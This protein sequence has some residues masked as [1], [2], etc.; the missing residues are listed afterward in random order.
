MAS[1]KVQ[2]YTNFPY[3][4]SSHTH[5][6]SSWLGFP[7]D[8]FFY[9]NKPLFLI[10][11]SKLSISRSQSRS[12]RSLS[13]MIYHPHLKAWKLEDGEAKVSVHVNMYKLEK[14]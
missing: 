11:N 12:S 9:E 10:L 8:E 7:S 1:K 5:S 13:L 3:S 14:T 4:I 2:S 6:D